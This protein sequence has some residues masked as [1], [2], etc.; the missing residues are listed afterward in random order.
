MK[1]DFLSTLEKFKRANDRVAEKYK[2]KITIKFCKDEYT[3]AD[4]RKEREK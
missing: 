4:K 1:K 3:L 2:C